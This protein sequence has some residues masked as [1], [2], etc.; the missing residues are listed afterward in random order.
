MNR[1]IA[2]ALFA[3]TTTPDTQPLAYHPNVDGTGDLPESGQ[4][5][6]LGG[7]LSNLA[8]APTQVQLQLY[9]DAARTQPLTELLALPINVSP[10]DPTKAG[11]NAAIE[12]W[13]MGPVFASCSTDTGTAGLTLC[14]WAL[15]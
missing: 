9:K 3:L 10:T 7:D 5:V 1:T 4:L 14:V 2:G 11:V 12:F 13:F 8:G 15:S 6:Q